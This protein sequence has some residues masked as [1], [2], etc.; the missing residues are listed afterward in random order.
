M[1]D[2]LELV[3]ESE[4]LLSKTKRKEQVEALQELGVELVKLSYQKLIKLDL[5]PALLDA[6]KLA[7]KI[8]SNGALRR[9]YQYIGKLMRTV[10][11]PAIAAK[12]AFMRG[13]SLQATQAFHLAEKWREQLLASDTAL[14]QFIVSYAGKPSF[15]MSAIDEL[16]QL[17]RAVR[18]EQQH[19][20]NRNYTKL[21]RL[22]KALMEDSN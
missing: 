17:I 13:E 2:N 12:L 7:Q 18:K 15:S 14:E 3:A 6:I 8:S 20:Q 10:D 4:L 9:Q 1:N 19:N 5:T 21:F 22:I 11:A 16:R